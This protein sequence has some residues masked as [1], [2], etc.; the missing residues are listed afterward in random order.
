MPFQGV[1]Y[2]GIDE[3]FSEEERIVR[4]TVRKFVGNR[5]VPIIEEC[6]NQAKFPKQ[7]IPE[8]S[9][10]GCIGPTIPEEY[11]GG[12]SSYSIYGLMMQEL[13][14]G[15]SGI[16]SFCSVMS[17]LVMYPIFTFG[18][19]EHRKNFLPKLAKGKMIGCFGLTEPNYGSNPA[20]LVTSAKNDGDFWVLNG[21]KTWI[22]NAG[23]ADVA[24]IWARTDEG[25]RGFVV[26]ADTKGFE[27]REIKNKF[28]LRASVTGE[29]FLEDC[30]IPAKNLLPGTSRGLGAALMCLT[31]ARYGIAWGGI[32]CAMAVYDATLKYA[33]E[34]IQFDK[35]IA[36]FQLVQSKLV[37]MLNE[38][39]KAQLLCWRLGRMMD[40]GKAK[41]NH[42]S[43]AKMNN[44]RMAL[45]A[46]RLGRDIHGAYGITTE[47]PIIRHML[48]M[49]S[50]NTYEGT[51]D[52]NRL[53][54]GRDITGL[55]AFK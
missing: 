12:G 38:I 6:F 8:L 55:E 30:R 16:R 48:N 35:P 25:I 33:K 23:M 32:G 4:D 46:A 14:R 9:E 41:Y 53:I 27:Q 10:L 3:L 19:E 31:Q 21:S 22:T 18:S 54:V 40:S 39:T 51:E 42:V 7:L 15:D 1:D 28:S 2:Y 43:L 11:G 36:G 29:I 20:G 17:S 44:V 52:V 26:E 45:D 37:G 13:E 5:I 47:Y 49:E 34:R 24:V 50:V